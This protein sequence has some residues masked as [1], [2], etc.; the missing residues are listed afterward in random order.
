MESCFSQKAETSD[1]A[2]NTTSD[3]ANDQNKFFDPS[4]SAPATSE[5]LKLFLK[6][7]TP[8]IFTNVLN[9][10]ATAINIVF[11]GHMDD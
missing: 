7:S 5:I 2:Q 10:V 1:C 6:L 11:A 9:F 3:E 8:A 4:E